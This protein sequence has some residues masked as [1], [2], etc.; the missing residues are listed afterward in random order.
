[1]TTDS[2]TKATATTTMA[3]PQVRNSRTYE[4]RRTG[5]AV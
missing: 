1:M 2:P 4:V 5:G 3:T